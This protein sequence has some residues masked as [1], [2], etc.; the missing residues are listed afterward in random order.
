MAIIVYICEKV[1][2]DLR[3]FIRLLE[4][5]S[6]SKVV[7]EASV[8]ELPLECQ[9]IVRQFHLETLIVHGYHLEQ[10]GISES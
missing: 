1:K 8:D 2:L 5:T 3:H 4:V 9:N 6:K 10:L 7:V